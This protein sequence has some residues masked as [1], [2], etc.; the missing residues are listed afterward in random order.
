MPIFGVNL[1]MTNLP[2]NQVKSMKAQG[3]D[4]NQIIRALQQDGYSSSVIFD[5]M[6]QADLPQNR[7]ED[8]PA[9]SVGNTKNQN[10]KDMS[11][12]NHEELIEAIIDEKWNDLMKDISKIVE[13]KNTA[14]TKL[15][16]MEQKFDDLK[17]QFDKL[18]E[19]ILSKIGEYDKNISTVG[20]EVKAM[21][22]VFAKVLPLFTENVAELKRITGSLKE[23][24]S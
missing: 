8:V 6:N 21:E 17:D 23:N 12:T 3:L 19:G 7:N 10:I 24:K 22:K 18:H 16:A 20:V 13:W 1:N 2:I 11:N 9:Y 5:A 4:N 15:I 14:D